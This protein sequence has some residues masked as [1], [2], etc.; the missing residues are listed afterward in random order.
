M[1]RLAPRGMLGLGLAL[2]FGVAAAA[3]EGG[4]PTAPP[5]RPAPADLVRLHPDLPADFRDWLR[6]FQPRA[7]AAGIS[8]V[9]LSRAMPT[10]RHR[11]DVIDLDRNQAEFTRQ[12]WDYLD[13]AVS[14]AR[15]EQGRALRARHL[16]TLRAIEARYGVPPAIVLAIWGMETN[17]GGYRGRTHILSA[18]ATLAHEGRRGAFFESELIAA[19]RIIEAGDADPASMRGSWA[20]A[21]GHTQFMPTSY[22]AYAVDFG[23]DGRR[24]VWSG[25]PTDALASTAA[26]LAAEGWQEGVP[27][28]FEVTL[29][30]GF[31]FEGTGRGRR[32]GVEEWMGRGVRMLS[33]GPLPDHGPA[34]II[35][36]A[37][38]RG[39][40]FIA[41]RNF[42][43]IARY[44]RA[45][46]YVV[47]VAHLADRI[48]GRGP[49]SRGWPRGEPALS[50]ADRR[51]LQEELKRTGFDP[52]GI[53]GRI[54]PATTDALRDWQRTQGMIA[55]GFPTRAI[56][57]RLREAPPCQC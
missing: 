37:G 20:G 49:F 7:V 51:A 35:T 22:L 21:M 44:N 27:W 40:A 5:P 57:E 39:P 1:H 56:L 14:D 46:S 19:L 17:F 43:V 9:T 6:A 53:D 36:P 47:A 23:G 2:A 45:L 25:D 24:D 10:I 42:D 13:N 3:S 34:A 29:P 16:E 26:F 32:A 4:G 55:D 28:A 33:G 15:V 48:D 50:A 30:E 11:R 31:D 8:Q 12:I 52:G 41:Y 18:L 38:V 54:G